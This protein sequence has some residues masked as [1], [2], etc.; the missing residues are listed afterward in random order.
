[1]RGATRFDRDHPPQ[2]VVWLLGAEQHDERH[3]GRSDAY[4]ILGRLD[5]RGELFPM[6]VD[7]KRLELDRRR[8]DSDSFVDDVHD[9]ACA[10]VGALS[11]GEQA[12]ALGGVAVRVIVEK[13]DLLVLHFAVSTN[14]ARG[15]L[16]GLEFPLT[17]QRFQAIQLGV[18]R[19][20]EA[21]HGPPA[22]LDELRDRSA[23]PGRLG[24]ERAFVALVE[25]P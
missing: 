6:T 10:L 8:R 18:R 3:K 5:D 22:L 2:G 23:F 15:R 12:T 25:R 9:D 13:G 17:E 24:P 11:V 7:Y 14:A 16:S 21:R 20:L 4:D 19:A 1:M